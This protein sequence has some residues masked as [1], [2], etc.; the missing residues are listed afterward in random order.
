MTSVLSGLCGSVV[1]L[2]S[3]SGR[4]VTKHWVHR[5]ALTEV[6]IPQVVGLRKAERLVLETFLAVDR[7]KSS[8]EGQSCVYSGRNSTR[9]ATTP[10]SA[11]RE[12][13][14]GPL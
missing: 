14:Q 1:A 4:T 3:T 10:S 12:D 9:E 11:N 5:K 6:R 8:V 7:R 2:E 13:A